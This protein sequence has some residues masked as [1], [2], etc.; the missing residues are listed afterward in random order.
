ML[1]KLESQAEEHRK[2]VNE[3]YITSRGYTDGEQRAILAAIRKAESF[4]ITPIR[5]GVKDKLINTLRA[6]ELCGWCVILLDNI[7][8]EGARDV[9]DR[10]LGFIRKWSLL[11]G[12][13]PDF[14]NGDLNE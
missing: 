7:E 3:I 1:K 10:Q 11:S 8:K 13:D 6:A 9:L 12:I 4:T 5:H 14:V 2:I